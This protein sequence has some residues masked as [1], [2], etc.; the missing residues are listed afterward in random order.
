MTDKAVGIKEI[1]SGLLIRLKRTLPLGMIPSSSQEE[2]SIL[3]T[4]VIT[5]SRTSKCNSI[6]PLGSTHQVRIAK[7][8]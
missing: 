4:K 1:P 6:A 5:R 2:Q 3:P 8:G 7:L